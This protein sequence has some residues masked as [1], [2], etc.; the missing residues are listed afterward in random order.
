MTESAALIDAL[1]CQRC[2]HPR[3]AGCTCHPDNPDEVADDSRERH[4]AAVRRATHT[5][6]E[7]DR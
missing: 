5:P 1:I 7:A 2:Y 3:L 6:R 4:A